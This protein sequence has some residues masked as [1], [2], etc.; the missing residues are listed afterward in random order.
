MHSEVA[1]VG[2]QLRVLRKLVWRLLVHSMLW[3]WG[4][5]FHYIM[6]SL[7]NI[8]DFLAEFWFSLF[9]KTTF[10]EMTPTRWRSRLTW[11]YGQRTSNPGWPFRAIRMALLMSNFIIT[12]F[13][14]TTL[15]GAR[16]DC[17]R[18]GSM[19]GGRQI[20]VHSAI[21]NGWK[22]SAGGKWPSWINTR[23]SLGRNVMKI[24]PLIGVTCLLEQIQ[25][26]NCES[27]SLHGVIA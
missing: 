18:C 27:A 3:I 26:H 19:A 7:P 5:S 1:I 12:N 16:I 24:K 17:S 8:A 9:Y 10:D 11:I 21:E 14:S 20:I 13:S 23:K 22:W 2:V 25:P 6:F 15:P 4:G